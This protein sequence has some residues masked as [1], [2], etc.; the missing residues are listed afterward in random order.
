MIG[1]GGCRVAPLG[2]EGVKSCFSMLKVTSFRGN[3]PFNRDMKKPGVAIQEMRF[4]S[5]Y[6]YRSV[7]FLQLFDK[8]SLI[9]FKLQLY[10]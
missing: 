6:S 8:V 5:N 1:G 4:T 3:I 9:Y 2:G 7:H 10:L